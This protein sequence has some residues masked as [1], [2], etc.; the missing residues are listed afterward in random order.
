MTMDVKAGVLLSLLVTAI[1]GLVTAI[2]NAEN[3][4]AL[5]NTSSVLLKSLTAPVDD[6]IFTFQWGEDAINKSI[7]MDGSPVNIEFKLA[8]SNVRAPIRLEMKS[9]SGK[10]VLNMHLIPTPLGYELLESYRDENVKFTDPS[11]ALEIRELVTTVDCKVWWEPAGGRV[12]NVLINDVKPP[13]LEVGNSSVRIP[14]FVVDKAVKIFVALDQ[15]N[16]TAFFEIGEGG[17][18]VV[19]TFKGSFTTAG[20]DYVYTVKQMVWSIAIPTTTP[21]NSTELGREEGR[22]VATKKAEESGR[23][24][25][26]QPTPTPTPSPAPQIGVGELTKPLTLVGVI[27]C[28]L[29]GIA[30]RKAWLIAVAVV[31][32]GA[33][34]F[35]GVI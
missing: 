12:I 9:Q 10:I 21:L 11:N 30:L 14:E 28:A 5:S 33:A 6:Y 23:Q 1:A 22:V 7:H 15:G 8:E 19:A 32:L 31:V 16:I 20:S 13:R 17:L 25:E 26:E 4:K 18:G 24:G 34:L 29:L 2:V 27:A 3:Q 35:L